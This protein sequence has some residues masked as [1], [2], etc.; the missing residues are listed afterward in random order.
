MRFR[1]SYCCYDVNLLHTFHFDASSPFVW[2]KMRGR[3]TVT[4]FWASG[5]TR[6]THTHTEHPTDNLKMYS[7][8]GRPRHWF[9]QPRIGFDSVFTASCCLNLALYI[10]W[11]EPHLIPDSDYMDSISQRELK[12]GDRNSFYEPL[13]VG[14]AD[15]AGTHLL[16]CQMLELFHRL[17]L[18]TKA[19]G[20]QSDST[21]T[22]ETSRSSF[23]HQ[24]TVTEKAWY[25]LHPLASFSLFSVIK[26][27]VKVMNKILQWRCKNNIQPLCCMSNFASFF[28]VLIS[29]YVFCFLFLYSTVWFQSTS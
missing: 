3:R 28:F 1:H 13:R 19:A 10:L 26:K 23:Q 14:W 12:Y 24:Q 6:T 21:E 27:L 15:T 25:T 7:V 2:R 4:H 18:H 11:I 22:I 16:T 29:F 9:T 5:H 8:I 20:T 17:W